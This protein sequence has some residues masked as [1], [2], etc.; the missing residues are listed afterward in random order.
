VLAIIALLSAKFFGLIWMDPVMGI[1]GAIL[2]ARW[3]LSLIRTTSGVLLDKQGPQSIQQKVKDRIEQ[4]DD[5]K[6]TDLH[7]YSIGPNIYSA[8]IAVVAH[9]P[10]TP[11]EYKKRIPTNLGLEHV[12]IE[13]HECPTHDPE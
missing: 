12:S 4:D 9:D 8:V 3:S 13:V 11:A 5:S 1:V 10:A 2:V 6:V 7:L